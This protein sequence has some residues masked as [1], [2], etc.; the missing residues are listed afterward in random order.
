[1]SAA[2]SGISIVGQIPNNRHRILQGSNLKYCV[3]DHIA[4]CIPSNK[5]TRW[6]SRLKDIRGLIIEGEPELASLK[7]RIEFSTILAAGVHLNLI[8]PIEAVPHLNRFLDATDGQGGILH[9]GLA[10]DSMHR[11]V[12]AC[13][14]AE[15]DLISQRL[16]SSPNCCYARFEELL[17]NGFLEESSSDGLLR[18]TFVFPSPFQGDPFIELIERQSFL[19]YGEAIS[20]I[21][22]EA[23]DCIAS[24]TAAH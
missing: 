20:P 16:R 5:R 4:V 10:V 9:V 11:A 22:V 24:P 1:M 2:W 23:L 6:M 13:Q 21:L 18:Q 12:T 15:L 3:I 14:F 17:R 7:S 8:S 19:G